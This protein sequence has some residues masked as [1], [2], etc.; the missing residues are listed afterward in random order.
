MSDTALDTIRNRI[1]ALRKA[2]QNSERSPGKALLDFERSGTDDELDL[3]VD[4][5]QALLHRHQS[6]KEPDRVGHHAPTGPFLNHILQSVPI[7]MAIF[8]RQ[9][10]YL[11]INRTAIRDDEIRNWIIGKTDFD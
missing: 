7:E 2:I 10:R 11:F 3:L 8:D 4:D 5:L 1:A 6:P 9:F